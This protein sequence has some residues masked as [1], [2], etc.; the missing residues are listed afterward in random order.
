MCLDALHGR[1][2]HS[3]QKKGPLNWCE[4]GYLQTALVPSTVCLGR[5]NQC[6]AGWTILQSNPDCRL[7]HFY[8]KGL[9]ITQSTT[10]ME[11]EAQEVDT[12]N[13][14]KL[15]NW[16]CCPEVLNVGANVFLGLQH[17]RLQNK[18]NNAPGLKVVKC[19]SC[20]R[21]MLV[22]NCFVEMSVNLENEKDGKVFSITAFPKVLTA[23]LKE[24]IFK[25]REDTDSLEVKLLTL[26]NMDFDLNPSGKI[27]KQILPHSGSLEQQVDCKKA[28][29]KKFNLPLLQFQKR[30][31]LLLVC[32]KHHEKSTSSTA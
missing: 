20:S 10:V 12:K 14:N 8:S 16:G 1:D 3:T 15:V 22:K 18:V 29:R 24:D 21:S 11:A 2:K 13:D 7:R 17:Q 6:H 30:E 27:V 5:P 4:M 9:T 31:N 32:S 26:E 28:T 23:F 25:Y 19:H